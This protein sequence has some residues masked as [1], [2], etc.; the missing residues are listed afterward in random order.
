MR[1]R[2]ERAVKNSPISGQMYWKAS[3]GM[4]ISRSNAE[5]QERK[6]YLLFWEM[7][8]LREYSRR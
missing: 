8:M 3:G 7:N 5:C 4:N 2:R 1:N 6:N